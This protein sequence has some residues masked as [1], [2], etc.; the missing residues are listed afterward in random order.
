M[1]VPLVLEK[2]RPGV[3]ATMKRGDAS[4]D[5]RPSS[6]LRPWQEVFGTELPCC[7]NASIA[8]DSK[9]G[10]ERARGA[11]V[12]RIDLD[13]ANVPQ[14]RRRSPSVYSLPGWMQWKDFAS[15]SLPSTTSEWL[16]QKPNPLHIPHCCP[17]L[18]RCTAYPSSA[19]RPVRSGWLKQKPTYLLA[20]MASNSVDRLN[21]S[22]IQFGNN[23]SRR[24]LSLRTAQLQIHLARRKL[25]ALP[26][27]NR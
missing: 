19:W 22:A 4:V 15:I 21:A 10:G 27:K 13:K 1:A 26:P 6:N 3:P 11:W 2:G 18:A 17:V 16:R 23:L 9:G 20:V 8:T 5:T 7:L 14:R 12:L 24:I 25:A